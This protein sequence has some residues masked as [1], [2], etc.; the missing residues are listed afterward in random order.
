MGFEVPSKNVLLG[1]NLSKLVVD[2]SVLIDSGESAL[3]L[4]CGI[5]TEHLFRSN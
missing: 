5:R 3:A 4:A 2:I 1:K